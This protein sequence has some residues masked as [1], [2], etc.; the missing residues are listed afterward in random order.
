MI[1][2][3]SRHKRVL[4]VDSTAVGASYITGIS[5]HCWFLNSAE[6]VKHAKWP[7]NCSKQQFFSNHRGF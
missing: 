5:Q 7:A 2:D 6:E 3:D 1:G 4:E